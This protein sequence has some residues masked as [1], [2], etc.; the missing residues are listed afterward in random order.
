MSSDDGGAAVGAD[1]K[2]K[3]VGCSDVLPAG[4]RCASRRAPSGA[5]RA[6]DLHFLHKPSHAC[7]AKRNHVVYLAVDIFA[8]QVTAAAAADPAAPC[9]TAVGQ[10]SKRKPLSLRIG[11]G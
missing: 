9:C 3:K 5:A 7:R 10:H 6:G 4:V 2:K 11:C 1:K 8:A